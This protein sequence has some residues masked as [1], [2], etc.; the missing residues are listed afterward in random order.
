MKTQTI[1]IRGMPTL[2][3]RKARAAA[4]AK[5]IPVRRFVTLAISEKIKREKKEDR[6]I[7]I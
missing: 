1:S 7:S 2:L 6:E 3:W 5:G 4:A